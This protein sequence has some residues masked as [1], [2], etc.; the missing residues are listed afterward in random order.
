MER[1]KNVLTHFC[2]DEHAHFVAL[3]ELLLAHASTSY[4]GLAGDML[5]GQSAAL[6]PALV[7]MLED[8]RFERLPQ[9]GS[10]PDTKS[11]V[12]KRHCSGYSRRAS[13]RG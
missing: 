2:S 11:T 1:R 13:M 5:T 7:R 12:S 3:A 9:N 8:D 6:E 10:L 4:D